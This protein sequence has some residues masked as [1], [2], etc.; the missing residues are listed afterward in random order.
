MEYIYQQNDGTTISQFI[1]V[2][3]ATWPSTFFALVSGFLEYCEDPALAIVR[4]CKE[5]L[6]L[7][8]QIKE[9]IGIY[10]FEMMNQVIMCY[11]V[12]AQGTKAPQDAI[13]LDTNEL[14]AYKIVA[15]KE[16]KPWPLGTGHAVAD[17]LKKHT[18]KL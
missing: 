11:H 15:M 5:E 18:S 7:D 6:G 2:R 10:P 12:V 1:L 17:F 16:L 14:A 8:V 3:N 9:M 4:E 13:V